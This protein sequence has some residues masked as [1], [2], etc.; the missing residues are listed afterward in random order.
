M[1][2]I[3]EGHYKSKFMYTHS[4]HEMRDSIIYAMV[5]V[6]QKLNYMLKNIFITCESAKK[7]DDGIL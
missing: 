3:F 4:L 5:N 6:S 2:I 1:T 7:L